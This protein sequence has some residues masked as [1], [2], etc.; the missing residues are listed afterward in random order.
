[1]LT[2]GDKFPQFQV[3][4]TVSNEL[5]NAFIDINQDTYKG[6][7]KVVFFYPKDFTF[8]CPT[9]IVAFSDR[10]KEFRDRNVEVVACS[11]DQ[12]FSHLAWNKVPRQEGGLGGVEYPIVADTTN[13][14]ATTY[15]VLHP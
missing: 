14:I 12:E 1:M 11:T 5:D 13:D 7:W 10:I 8:V 3:K 6:K 9:E 15:G 4:A 2:V